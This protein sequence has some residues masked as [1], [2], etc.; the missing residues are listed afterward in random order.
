MLRKSLPLR[1]A[2]IMS[3][4]VL[5]ILVI[6]A[7]ISTRIA[8][9]QF[10]DLADEKYK[11]MANYYGEVM[12]KWFQKNSSFLTTAAAAIEKYEG[13]VEDMGPLLKNFVDSNDSISEMYYG[14]FDNHYAFAVWTP[15]EDYDITSR[16]WYIDTVNAGGMYFVE[17]YVDMI[18]NALC[19]SICLPMP[20]GVL[21][22]DLNLDQLTSYIPDLDNGEYIFLVTDTGVIVTHPNGGFS[23]NGDQSV[24]LND[25]LSGA[26]AKAITDDSAF[27]D[28]NGK[29][30]YITSYTADNG[31]LVCLVTPKSVYDTA[32]RTLIMTF[33]VMTV[34]LCVFAIV[35]ASVMGF[36]I[37]KPIVQAA[38][39][40]QHI[41][42]GI[43]QSQGD[44]SARLS[45]KSSDEVGTMTKGVNALIEQI[46]QI[47]GSVRVSS[48]TVGKESGGLVSTTGQLTSAVDGIST[49]VDEIASGATN[50]ANDIQEATVN[51]ERIGT[52]LEE[53][54]DIANEL[55]RVATDMQAASQQSEQK[56]TELN[57]SSQ[58]VTDGIVQVSDQIGNTNRAVDII[59][60]KVSAINDIASQTNLLALNAS[61][62]AARA[63]D[64]GR[65]FAVV[66]EEIGKLA[67]DSAGSANAIKDEM[68]SLLLS[69]QS[70]V[71][72]SDEIRK[73]TEAQQSAVSDATDSI[74]ALLQ[75]IA[76]TMENIGIIHEKI[77]ACTDARRVVADA[78]SSLSAV[79]EENAASTEETS[80]T[81][82]ELNAT[83]A[84][85]AQS[86]Q[87]LQGVTEQLNRQLGIFK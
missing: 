19:L 30:S 70:A 13:N 86:A 66:A 37:A 67:V 34:I 35:I 29:K 46:E 23:I 50:Q 57:R 3:S 80:A 38:R 24:K 1:I 84:T 64:A 59:N 47:I 68:A 52:A 21:G 63:G 36:S 81:T 6:N 61:I 14:T 72:R 27:K 8:K 20:E 22:V 12:D 48:N 45:D 75:N 74:K 60:E 87:E 2:A 51:V 55:T 58:A 44:L 15:P 43:S 10:E 40:V 76:T 32:T 17:P 18:T 62:E 79:S 85:L 65:G 7:V 28:Y 53:V 71:T 26:Y 83:I 9:S 42:D 31:W 33:T 69:A 11:N 41:I 49:A 73:L 78:M 25:A 4:M 5:V 56:M 54:A 82:Q 39:E 77:E 16:Q